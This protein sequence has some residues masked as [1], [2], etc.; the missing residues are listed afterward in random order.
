MTE[1]DRQ[2]RAEETAVEFMIEHGYMTVGEGAKMLG[3]SRQLLHSRV[4]TLKPPKRRAK[5]LQAMFDHTRQWFYLN[6]I[7]QG[8]TQ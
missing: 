6:D 3:I 1:Q 5:Y 2:R 8:A 7:K 4:H